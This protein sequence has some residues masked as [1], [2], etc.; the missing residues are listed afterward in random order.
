MKTENTGHTRRNLVIFSI[1]AIAAGWLGRW[2]DS[3][4]GNP[5]PEQSP[6]MLIWI[7]SPLVTALILRIFAGDGWQDFGIRWNI[8]GNLA[9]YGV[10]LL[11]YPVCLAII[12][13]TGLAFSKITMAAVG[14]A[15]L[16]STTV[17]V[18]IQQM[19]K[20]VFEEFAFR[21]YLAPK[22][23]SLSLN[24]FI[25]HAVVGLVWGLWHV[26]YIR[27][28]TTYSTEALAT[29]V[30]RFLLGAIAASVVYGEIRL[31]TNSVWP[32]WLMHTVGATVAGVPIICGL[33][34]FSDNSGT[35]VLPVFESWM[36]I[37][38]FLL[39]GIGLYHWRTKKN[40]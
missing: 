12:V 34:H 5:A 18:L 14:T 7:L 33:Y 37:G 30:P 23:Y 29:L 39:A 25:A 3:A 20:N 27:A 22:I 10:S 16:I 11:V 2:L 36:M 32:A 28:I 31:K 4:M 1:S 8:K 9:W 15:F 13:L 21:G 6:G 40:G 17:M 26:P 35:C 24:T 19:I 38:L